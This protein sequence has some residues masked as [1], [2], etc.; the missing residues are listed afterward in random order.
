MRHADGLEPVRS[1]WIGSRLPDA[2]RACVESFMRVGHPFELFTYGAVENV[3]DGARVRDA[4]EIVSR[5]RVFRYGPAAGPGAGSLGAFSNL[6]RYTLLDREGGYWVDCDMFCLRPLPRAS[7]V[8][9]SERRKNGDRTSNCGVLKFPA[10]SDFARYCLRRAEEHAVGDLV[11]GKTGPAL[12]AEAVGALGLESLVSP[13][14]DYCSVDWAAF[15]SLCRPGALHRGAYAVH[16]WGEM[17]RREDAGDGAIPWPGP[18]G[19]ILHTLSRMDRE[20]IP[21]R[22]TWLR[23]SRPERIPGRDVV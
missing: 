3:P 10:G 4:G 17:W 19:S 11:Y 18:E 2:Q 23:K 5:E 21:G 13:P 16:L 15:R 8:I 7:V 1:L 9:S 6:F 20:E 12:V 22:W 14:D